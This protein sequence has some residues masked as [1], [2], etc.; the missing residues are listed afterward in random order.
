MNEYI[1]YRETDCD[2]IGTIPSSWRLLRGRFL[3]R[4]IKEINHDMQCKNLLSL[5]YDGVL[6]K[7][8]F[9]SEGLRPENYNTYQIFQKDNLVFKMIDLE[10]VK[11]SRVGIVHEKGIMSSAYIRFEVIKT[12]IEPKFAYWFYYDLYKK[13]IYNSI[14][15]GVRSTLS[16]SDLL[17]MELPVPRLE[18]QKLISSYL[19]NK[20]K[21][22]DRLV[23][24]TQK[25]IELLKEQRTALINRYVTKG[26]DPN[27]EM[28]DSGVEW[29]GEIPKHWKISP[30]FTLF[31]ENKMKNI[32]GRLDVLTLSYGKIKY[33]DLSKNEGLVPES[34]DGY[35]VMNI[36]SLIIRS[37]DLQ[38]DHKSL[39]VGHVGIEGVIT[40]AYLGLNPKEQISTKYFYYLI[41]LA[42]LKKVLYGLGGGLRQSLRY[43]DFKRFPILNPH[44]HEREEIAETLD[45]IDNKTNILIEKLNSRINLLKEYRQSLISSVVTGKVRVSEDML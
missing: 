9:G 38:N 34:F 6:N 17:E 40:S 32:E 28:K 29:I 35:Q 8:F 24:K 26:L 37:T 20:T 15:S 2:W 41:H 19:D 1:S 7:N 36:E 13:E 5:T 31:H 45:D 4:S 44:Q 16:S 12:K 30:M 21:Q 11:T 18:E 14:G 33:R 27:V 3:F 23:E 42:D 39:R 25:K 10:N 43:D 22:I